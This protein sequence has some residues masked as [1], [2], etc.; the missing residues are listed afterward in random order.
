M[1]N[2]LTSGDQPHPDEDGLCLFDDGNHRWAWLGA[3]AG[4]SPGVAANQFLIEH[5]GRGCLL[6]PGSVLDFARSVAN[7]ARFTD[8][9]HIDYLFFSHQDPDVSSSAPMWSAISQ[10]KLV[11]PALWTRFLPHFGAFD[12]QRIHAVADAGD[13]LD[14]AG[15][16]LEILPA[17]FLHAPGNIVLYDPTARLLFSG[18]IGANLPPPG[19]PLFIDDFQA[20]LPHLEG[21]H[22]RY[23]SCNTAC[24]RF[25]ERVRDLPI[26]GLVPQHG[27]I[28][29]GDAARHFLAWLAELRCGS[30]L[31]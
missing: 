12:E 9:A 5:H 20:H 1:L 17:H 11:M 30:D 14:L 19:S 2:L 23:M 21:F 13:Q 6:D 8:A 16:T 24:R 22:Q 29:R 3:D 7:I 10:A 4:I 26:D 25:V 31:L 15:A 27:S 18:D 28:Y